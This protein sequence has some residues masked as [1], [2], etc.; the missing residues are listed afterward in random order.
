MN[1]RTEKDLLAGRK[2]CH[3]MTEAELKAERDEFTALLR[4][5]RLTPHQCRRL[6]R[7]CNAIEDIRATRRLL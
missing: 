7:V 1:E 2:K 5:G 4:Q 6:Q 3:D